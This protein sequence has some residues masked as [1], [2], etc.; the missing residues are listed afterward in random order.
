MN[1]LEIGMMVDSLE[2]V[3]QFNEKNIEGVPLKMV[4]LLVYQNSKVLCN[5][6]TYY[7]IICI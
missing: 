7:K 3:Y 2:L 4:K 5:I 1:L 6:M